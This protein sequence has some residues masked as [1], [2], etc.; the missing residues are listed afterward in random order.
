MK[1]LILLSILFIIGCEETDLLTEH[2]HDD[3]SITI[4]DKFN[5]LN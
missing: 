4:T 3:T 5:K 1:K 2:T